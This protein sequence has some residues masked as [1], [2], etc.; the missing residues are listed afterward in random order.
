MQV[1]PTVSSETGF[2][3]RR[4]KLSFASKKETRFLSPHRQPPETGFLFGIS[5]LSLASKQET[6]FLNPRTDI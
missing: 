3:L 2:L 1:H 6:R 5:E 4:S